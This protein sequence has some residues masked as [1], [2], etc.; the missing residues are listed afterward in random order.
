V[1]RAARDSGRKIRFA[2]NLLRIRKI[3][4]TK[5]NKSHKDYLSSSLCDFFAFVVK[6]IMKYNSDIFILSGEYKGIFCN[7][8]RKDFLYEYS[9]ID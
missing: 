5:A 6:K 3:S 2:K 1:F 8:S 7:K 9:V 4:T